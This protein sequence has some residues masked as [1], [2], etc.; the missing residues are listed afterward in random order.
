MLPNCKW[1]SL[2]NP[3]VWYSSLNPI[4]DA[5]F[6]ILQHNHPCERGSKIMKKPNVNSFILHE[7]SSL[8]RE[9]K[10]C[11]LTT[12]KEEK[13]HLQYSLLH[14]S[15]CSWN[16]VLY[17]TSS[18]IVFSLVLFLLSGPR[19]SI[20]S[21]P[22]RKQNYLP[23]WARPILPSLLRSMILDLQFVGHLP[24]LLAFNLC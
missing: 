6:D 15:N 19:S 23:L 16:I 17:M 4:L 11:K 13:T 14:P 7:D 2:S 22:M 20:M 1:N 12:E 9:S 10:V 8:L 5:S 21:M 3:R 24:H 18:R